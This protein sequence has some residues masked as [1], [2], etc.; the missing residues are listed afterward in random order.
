MNF[1]FSLFFAIATTLIVAIGLALF[2]NFGLLSAAIATC[3]VSATAAIAFR[4]FKDWRSFNKRKKALA[5]AMTAI[6]C[7]IFF[8]ISAAFW[9]SD[10]V[11]TSRLNASYNSPFIEPDIR[12]SI[13]HGKGMCVTVE[14]IVD[15]EKSMDEIRSDLKRRFDNNPRLRIRWEVKTKDGKTFECSDHELFLEQNKIEDA[16]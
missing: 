13:F 16:G 6:Y 9:M 1:R 5:C 12:F 10:A 3:F 15:S 11:Q 2:I 4:C 7:F 14:G 8:M